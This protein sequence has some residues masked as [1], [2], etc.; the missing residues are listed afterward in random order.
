ML[1]I[2]NIE[3]RRG[4]KALVKNFCHE[5]SPGKL[6]VIAGPNGAGKSTLLKVISGEW[7][8]DMG[9]VFWDGDNIL[10]LKTD[11]MGRRRSFLHQETHLDFSFTVLEVV[12]LGRYPH[13]EGNETP[14]DLEIARQALACFDMTDFSGRDYTTLSGGEKQRVQLARSLAQVWQP[15]PEGCYWMLDEPVNNLDPAHQ[16]SALKVMRQWA[17]KGA[18]VIT[19]L[20]DLNLILE[21]GDE[22]LLMKSGELLAG[23]PPRE[24]FNREN[25]QRAF[26][27]E[28]DVVEVPGRAVPVVVAR[29]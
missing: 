4:G 17:D 1:I 5:F 19:V 29:I 8:A 25:L 12:L 28:M 24:V 16:R 10:Q 22:V 27:L 21:F 14:E 7:T 15:L 9:E 13:G 11:V 18:T 3:L 20:H 6:S 2:K 26:D 23:G